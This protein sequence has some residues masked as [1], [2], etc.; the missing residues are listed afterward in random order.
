MGI[1]ELEPRRMDTLKSRAYLARL[2]CYG[3]I[4]ATMSYAAAG[5]KAMPQNSVSNLNKFMMNRCC[6]SSC[7]LVSVFGDVS[8]S[9]NVPAL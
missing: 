6:C 3:V 7:Y 9:L 5:H 2:L 1:A 8:Q 4:I